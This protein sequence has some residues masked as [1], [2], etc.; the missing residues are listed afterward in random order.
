MTTNIPPHPEVIEAVE[1]VWGIPLQT[2]GCPTCRRTF[3]VTEGKI[4]TICPACGQGKLEAQAAYSRKEPPELMIPFQKK[5][6]ALEPVLDSFVGGL[7]LA[8]DDFNASNLTKRAIPMFFP[9]WLVDGEVAGGWQAEAGYD[10]QVKS[11]KE[12]YTSGQWRSQDVLESRARWEFRVGQIKR[13]YN[14]IMVP[15]CRDHS[16]TSQQLG[17]YSYGQ[18]HSY[19]PEMIGEAVLR[20]PDLEPD[21]VW[22]SVRNN[23]IQAA[24][25]DCQRAAEAQHIR[26][27]SLEADYEKLN[28]TQLL[29][30][31]YF[32]YYKDD[33]S[34]VVPVYI[35]GQ[36]G[37]ISGQRLASQ[38]KGNRMAAIS[39]AVGGGFLLFGLL[40]FLLAILL[41]P[42]GVV[43]MALVVIGLFIG[44]FALVPLIYPWQNNRD[45]IEPKI[46]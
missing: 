14:N 1:Q 35:N 18:Y 45:Q 33:E 28:W 27:F 38:K 21:E 42:V 46:K 13:P 9:M 12:S 44:A 2:T 6:A 10:Y 39:G 25:Q 43:A 11:S 37:K 4:G 16:K 24:A 8:P 19:A 34:R 7:W 15:A 36:T 31:M 30:P 26:S 3:L 22:D 41:P 23:F 17:A 29:L 40:C 5:M 20:I 32:T